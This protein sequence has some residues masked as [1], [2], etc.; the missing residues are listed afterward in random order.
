LI[1]CKFFNEFSYFSVVIY[2]IQQLHKKHHSYKKITFIEV[3][4][5]NLKKSLK[6]ILKLSLPPETDQ[7][8]QNIYKKKGIQDPIETQNILS[9][10]QPWMIKSLPLDRKNM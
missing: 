3:N 6:K 9:F 1:S 8:T 5:E 7:T 10:V 2:K 4:P